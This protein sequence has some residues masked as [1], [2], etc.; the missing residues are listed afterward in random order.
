MGADFVF[1]NSLAGHYAVLLKDAEKLGLKE[2]IQFCVGSGAGQPELI[3]LAGSAAEGAWS[4]NVYPSWPND[5]KGYKWVVEEFERQGR[6]PKSDDTCGGISFARLGC[7]AIRTA[8]KKVGPENVDNNSIYDALCNLKDLD[9]WGLM[10]N[11][12]YAP[13][14]RIP[15]NYYYVLE[16]KDKKWRDRAYVEVPWF[17]KK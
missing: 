6:T 2:K 8:A 10:P 3:K 11:I 14:L 1:M 7:E 13:D 12:S 16:V 15:F 4:T 5:S 17:I 9:M